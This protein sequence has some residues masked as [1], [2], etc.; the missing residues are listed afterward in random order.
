MGI[1]MEV[2]GHFAKCEYVSEKKNALS[3][4]FFVVAVFYR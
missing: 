3:Y 2:G 4:K 1:V